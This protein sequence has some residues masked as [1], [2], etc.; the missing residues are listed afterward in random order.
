M[1]IPP[2]ILASGGSGGGGGPSGPSSTQWRV[3]ALNS[4]DPDFISIQ[5]IE[6]AET[7]SGANACTGGTASAGANRTSFPA[8]EAFDGDKTSTAHGWSV[9]KSTDVDQRDWWIQYTFPAAVSIAELRM[10]A[11]NDQYSYH[12]PL[13]FLLQYFDGSNWVTHF[14]VI[15]ENVWQVAE[16]RTFT[17]DSDNRATGA[18][19]YWRVVGADSGNG[20]YMHI[21]ELEMRTSVGGSDITSTS[22]A[23][24]G[25]NRTGFEDTKA[26]DNTVSGNNS[27]GI[28]FSTMPVEERWV[29][30]DFGTA[31]EIV[32]IDVSARA[33]GSPTQAPY[34]MIVESS[35]DLVTWNHRWLIEDNSA[36][37]TSS[38]SRTFT[39]P[40]ALDELKLSFENGTDGNQDA[41]DESSK[42]TVITWGGSSKV[43]NS[44]VLEGL[45]SLDINSDGASGDS[46]Q[47]PAINFG[48]STDFTIEAWVYSTAYDATFYHSLMGNFL[49]SDLTGSWS[50][51]VT[52]TPTTYLRFQADNTTFIITTTAAVPLNT[53]NHVALVRNG[54]AWNLFLNGVSVGSASS[55]TQAVAG[56]GGIRI[57]GNQAG[58]LDEWRG[59][60]DLVRIT[61]G[62]ARYTHS[63]YPPERF[64]D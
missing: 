17:A 52:D 11:R 33:D 47:I 10:W 22:N 39:D 41:T 34:S 63:F 55:S 46:A 37:W 2:G 53:W 44:T 59:Y 8:S 15:G 61:K 23:I 1:S 31:Q 60:L 5:E 25:N 28:Q 51:F 35:T 50:L 62:L 38:E 21:A 14:S 16:T 3:L 18:A 29:G 7:V 27:W 43:Q 20:V 57:G 19:R 45:L 13:T 56:T 36:T 42:S 58:S 26:F 64:W 49:S 12:M 4:L 40:G 30:Q 32:E 54:S 9:D 48:T 24:S 6:M